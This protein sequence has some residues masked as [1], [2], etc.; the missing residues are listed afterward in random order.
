MLKKKGVEKDVIV[1]GFMI[2]SIAMIGQTEKKK[3]GILN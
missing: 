3:V 1:V 2:F